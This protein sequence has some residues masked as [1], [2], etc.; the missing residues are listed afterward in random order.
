MDEND[1]V[2]VIESEDDSWIRIGDDGTDLKLKH[3]SSDEFK[4]V[5]APLDRSFLIG[6]EGCWNTA[7]LA[8][9]NNFIEIHFVTTNDDTIS[10]GKDVGKGNYICMKPV[11]TAAPSS[12]PTASP[13]PP[14]TRRML[15]DSNRK[16]QGLRG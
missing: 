12:S 11:C 15:F 14:N 2:S 7:D 8:V 5:G 6:Y 3:S 4:Y 10:S 1:G 16:T 9:M 13:I